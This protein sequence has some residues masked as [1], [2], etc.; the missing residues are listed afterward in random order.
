MGVGGDT[1]AFL[2]SL[3]MP[4]GDA[5][6]NFLQ[7]GEMEYKAGFSQRNVNSHWT[8]EQLRFTLLGEMGAGDHTCTCHCAGPLGSGAKARR[9]R[10]WP[11]R[12]PQLQRQG[13]LAPPSGGE[14]GTIPLRQSSSRAAVCTRVCSQEA[15]FPTK[16]VR[17]SG[18]RT[19]PCA[20]RGQ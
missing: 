16:A 8:E 7:C 17:G 13:V 9:K 14:L 18:N 15:C 20:S 4:C 6:D 1:K 2:H 3:Q 10:L 12:K 11:T 19:S 5:T